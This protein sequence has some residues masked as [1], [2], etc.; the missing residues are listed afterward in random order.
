[1][2][3]NPQ[4]IPCC[5]CGKKALFSYMPGDDNY[6]DKCVPRGCSCNEDEN[7]KEELDEHG[8]RSPCVEYT[9]INN[10][11]HNDADLVKWGWEEYYKMNPDKYKDISEDDFNFGNRKVKDF[12]PKRKQKSLKKSWKEHDSKPNGFKYNRRKKK[13]DVE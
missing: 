13:K 3:D 10:S 5:N 8:R 1:M 7:G 12:V 2:S 6:C 11:D 9:L 4:F